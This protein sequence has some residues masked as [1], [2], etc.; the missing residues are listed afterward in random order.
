MRQIVREATTD[1]RPP[2]EVQWVVDVD[3]QDLL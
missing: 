2:D 1:L 3:P